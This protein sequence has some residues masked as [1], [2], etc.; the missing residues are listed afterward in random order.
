MAQAIDERFQTSFCG[1][2]CLSELGKPGIGTFL[3]LNEFGKPGIRTLLRLSEFG[4]PR[5]GF[6]E[7]PHA[8]LEDFADAMD[9]FIHL[10]HANLCLRLSLQDELDG[11][12]DIH[13]ASIAW[14][15]RRLTFR[16]LIGCN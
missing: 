11:T 12:F 7:H 15:S 5:V 16:P 4:K 9:A 6:D 8:L 13:S 1:R 3:C 14:L 10:V 2:L